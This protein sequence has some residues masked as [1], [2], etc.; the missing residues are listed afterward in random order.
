VN[1]PFL[2]RR[3]SPAFSGLDHSGV[4]SARFGRGVRKQVAVRKRNPI[5]DTHFDDVRRKRHVLDRNGKRRTFGLW[6][7]GSPKEKACYTSERCRAVCQAEKSNH[8]ITGSREARLKVLRMFQVS[9][10]GGAN[11]YQERF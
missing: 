3:I 2:F 7:G 10:K 9:D 11:L 4:E 8:P 5:A 6:R 1:A